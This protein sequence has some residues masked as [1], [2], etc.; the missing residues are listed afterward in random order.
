MTHVPLTGGAAARRN[1]P[2]GVGHLGDAVA[3][4][5][6]AADLVGRAEAVLQRAHEA[7]RVLPVALELAHDVDE[8]LEQARAGD[9]AVFRDVADEQQREVALLRDADERRRDLAHLAGLAGQPVGERRR[10]GLHRVDDEQV[11]RDRV[12]LAEDRGEVGLGGEVELGMQCAGA[13]G[14]QA[15]LGRSTPRR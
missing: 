8:V 9:R 5:L 6:E 12:D 3:G 7:Q 15:H 14:A 1:S 13:P 11:G 4:H 2:R 10:H